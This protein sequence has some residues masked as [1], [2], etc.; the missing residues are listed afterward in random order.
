ML[1]SKKTDKEKDMFYD[2]DNNEDAEMKRKE[3]EVILPPELE[4][5]DEDFDFEEEESTEEIN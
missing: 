5:D 2:A 4:K 1:F 3:N